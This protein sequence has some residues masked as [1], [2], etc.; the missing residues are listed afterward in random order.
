VNQDV[1]TILFIDIM[2]SQNI[3]SVYSIIFLAL[4]VTVIIIVLI[5]RQYRV[6]QHVRLI[7]TTAYSLYIPCFSKSQLTIN[8]FL[9]M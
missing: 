8:M 9:L 3:A 5:I 2:P 7:V 1:V 4:T 6:P